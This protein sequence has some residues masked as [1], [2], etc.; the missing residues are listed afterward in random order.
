MLCV[1]TCISKTLTCASK[2]LARACHVI[3]SIGCEGWRGE[4]TDRKK[5]DGRLGSGQIT[6]PLLSLP[7]KANPHLP[8]SHATSARLLRLFLRVYLRLQR[9]GSKGGE[10]DGWP[11]DF[12]EGSGA[13]GRR[14]GGPGVGAMARPGGDGTI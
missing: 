7:H 12:F 3:R 8:G 1:R 6:P 10:Q 9:D 13:Q 2:A 4:K 5:E 11:A 14:R